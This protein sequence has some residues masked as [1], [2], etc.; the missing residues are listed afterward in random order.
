MTKLLIFIGEDQKFDV[1]TLIDAIVSMAGTTKAKRGNFIGAIFECEYGCAEESTI[2]RISPDAETVTASGLG[3]SSLSFAVE[4]QKMTAVDLHAIDTDYSFNV[5][6]RDFQT[7]E[8]LAHAV[9][10]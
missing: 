2:I 10:L 8:S 3:T 4:L 7:V 9:H 5:A 6:L 1:D